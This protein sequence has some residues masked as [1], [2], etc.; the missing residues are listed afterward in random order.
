M[1]NKNYLKKGI[2][3]LCLVGST[4]CSN[5]IKASDILKSDITL[6]QDNTTIKADPYKSNRP[7][8]DKRLFTSKAVENEIVRIKKMLKNPKM[9]WMFENCFPNTLD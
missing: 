9:A 5:E 4:L 8:V 1:Q 3:G 2:L 6:V 7:A